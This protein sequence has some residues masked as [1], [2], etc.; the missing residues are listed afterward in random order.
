MNQAWLRI[1]DAAEYC[2]VCKRT[3]MSWL[4]DE[5]LRYAKIR[6]TVLIKSEWLDAFLGQYEANGGRNVDCIVDETLRE[7]SLKDKI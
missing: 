6:G 4:K 7:L 2:G 1:K 5:G 3:L